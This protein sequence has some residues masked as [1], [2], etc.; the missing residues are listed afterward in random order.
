[1]VEVDSLEA[2][3]SSL[4]CDYNYINVS[5]VIQDFSISG[6]VLTITGTQLPSS[7]DEIRSITFAKHDCPILAASESEITC[8]VTQV[9]GK[10][11]PEVIDQKG[12]IPVTVE[13]TI[14]IALV[15]SSVS[16]SS[17]LNLEGGNAIVINGQ[18]FPN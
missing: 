14:D 3:C 15:V 18:N 9:A 5:A 13:K 12:I 4:L 16:P 17:N 7:A 11:Q 2:V 6:N 1:M 8:T 10:W